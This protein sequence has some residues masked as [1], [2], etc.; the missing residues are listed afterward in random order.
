MEKVTEKSDKKYR[1]RHL[2]FFNSL[3]YWEKHFNA[4]FAIEDINGK[5][6]DIPVGLSEFYGQR[7]MGKNVN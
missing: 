1:R 4:G 2:E 7:R 5:K 3:S 6:Q